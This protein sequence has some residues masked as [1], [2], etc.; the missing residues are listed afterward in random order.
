MTIQR[1]KYKDHS[2]CYSLVDTQPTKFANPKEANFDILGG[3][4]KPW[5]HKAR[6]LCYQL[7]SNPLKNLAALC[8]VT[9]HQNKDSQVKAH[10]FTLRSKWSSDNTKALFALRDS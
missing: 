9:P 7:T 2:L 5:F 8:T 1:E 3:I 4:I 10:S 6:N